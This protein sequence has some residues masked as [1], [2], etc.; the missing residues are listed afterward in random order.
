MGAVEGEDNS[1]V[2]EK[3]FDEILSVQ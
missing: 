3:F 2:I 1:E